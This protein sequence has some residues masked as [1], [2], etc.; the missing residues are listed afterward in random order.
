MTT[1]IRVDGTYA[2]ECALLRERTR[3]HVEEFH[4]HD[5]NYQPARRDVSVQDAEWVANEFDPMLVWAD[6]PTC[7][8]CPEGCEDCTR[9]CFR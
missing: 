5:G 1:Y 8:G 6:V 2:I 3:L 4:D 7:D 9:E